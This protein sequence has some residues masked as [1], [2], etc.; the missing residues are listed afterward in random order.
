MKVRDVVGW[1]R[2]HSVELATVTAP[3]VAAV[4]VHPGWAAL[5]VAAGAGW[6]LIEVRA[7]RDIPPV[8]PGPLHGVTDGS[9]CDSDQ[10]EDVTA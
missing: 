10:T 1:V 7:R 4:T 6:V 3:A 5:T 2:W 9:D 8:P